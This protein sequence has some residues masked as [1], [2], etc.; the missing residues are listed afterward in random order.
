MIEAVNLTKSFKSSVAVDHINF[1]IEPGEI[2][3]MLGP[4]GAGKST[5]IAMLSTLIPPTEGDVLLH[6]KSVLKDQNLLRKVLGVV[7]QEIALYGDLTAKENL[8]FFGNLYKIP[9]KQLNERV[10]IVLEQ[11]G[12]E[13]ETKKLVKHYSGG[14]KRR[15]NIG[16]ALLHEPQYL[17]MDE[18]TVGI[19]PQSRNHILE[20]VKKL[21]EQ[22]NTAIIYTSHYME[23]VEYLCNR[24]YIMD[25]GRIIASGSKDEIKAILSSENT[26]V[27]KVNNNSNAFMNELFNQPILTNIK[28]DEDKINFT[29]AKGV[30]FLPNLLSLCERHNVLL[31][32]FQM[33][34]PTLEDVFLHLTG[35]AL[36]N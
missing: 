34:E 32:S 33:E 17:I 4:N 18:P 15:L 8:F 22:S 24:I 6:Q 9:K 25:Q 29:I 28:A 5:T 1:Y 27:V 14:M 26:V 11:I 7:P 19:D 12:L 20:T 2:V 36:R 3:G 35:R 30:N 13:N 23:E 16:V 10:E 31:K 21:N